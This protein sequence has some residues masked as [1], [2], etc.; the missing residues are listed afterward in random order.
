VGR[1]D[2]VATF[3]ADNRGDLQAAAALTFTVTPLSA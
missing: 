1:F 3:V 2:D